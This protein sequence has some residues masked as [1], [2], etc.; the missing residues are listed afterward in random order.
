MYEDS[1]GG[2]EMLDSP[3]F[4]I[5]LVL[6]GPGELLSLSDLSPRVLFVPSTISPFMPCFMTY[7]QSFPPPPTQPLAERQMGEEGG[8]KG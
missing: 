8:E 2:G 4:L 6:P 1:W 3:P 7:L 5:S